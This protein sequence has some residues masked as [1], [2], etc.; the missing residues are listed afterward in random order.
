MPPNEDDP[1]FEDTVAGSWA[2]VRD[3]H[4]AEALTMLESLVL[5][6]PENP[7]AHFEYAGLL[8]F[9]G[10]E[11]EAVAPYRRAQALGLAGVDLPR[12]YAQLGS[13]LRNVGDLDGALAVLDEGQQRFPDYAAIRAIRALALVSAGRCSEAMSELIETFVVTPGVDLDGYERALRAYAS[14][15]GVNNH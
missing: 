8:D 6:H 7:R 3:G 14:A 5:S 9:L 1:R 12:L 10:R 15:L 11:A 13:T 2:L 4:A